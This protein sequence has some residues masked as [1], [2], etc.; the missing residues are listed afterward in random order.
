MNKDTITGFV[1]I[2]LIL[3]AFTWYNQPSAEQ[4]LSFVVLAFQLAK[5]PI[6]VNYQLDFLTPGI[7]PAN[8]ISRKLIRE[9]PN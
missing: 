6:I 3:V 1:L 2:A 7:K 4:I 5:L 9:M 8:A